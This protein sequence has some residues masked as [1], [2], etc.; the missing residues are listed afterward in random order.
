MKRR[1]WKT[2]SSTEQLTEVKVG[3]R[4]RNNISGEEFE[5]VKVGDIVD[6]VLQ[7]E[8]RRVIHPESTFRY[9]DE[10]WGFA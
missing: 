9:S 10:K 4:I 3:M 2:I 8:G 6:G 7:V 5:V 1:K